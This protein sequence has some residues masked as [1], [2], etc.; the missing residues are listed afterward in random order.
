MKEST[1]EVDKNTVAMVRTN[2]GCK[3]EVV[4]HV[5]QNMSMIESVFQSLPHC[6]LDIFATGKL[7]NRRGEYGLEIPVNFHFNG[8]GQV[9]KPVKHKM[10]KNAVALWFVLVLAAKKRWLAMCS[11]ISP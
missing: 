11:R 3:E 9:I 6:A 2:S 5:Q 4:G 1:N 10:D 7:I 8:P